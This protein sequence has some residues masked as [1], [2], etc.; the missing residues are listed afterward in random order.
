MKKAI[1]FLLILIIYSSCGKK[2]SEVN[3]DYIG[4]WAWSSGNQSGDACNQFISIDNDDKAYY[5]YGG[6]DMCHDRIKGT[7]RLTHKALMIGIRR[8]KII[9]E[10][11]YIP[12]TV[13]F[14]S[15]TCN[16]RMQLLIPHWL[17]CSRRVYSFYKKKNS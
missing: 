4:T 12:D 8:F 9:E 3:K 10:P 11:V 13:L 15:D 1:V 5:S 17:Q 2:V 14:I 16:M 6:I 7:G